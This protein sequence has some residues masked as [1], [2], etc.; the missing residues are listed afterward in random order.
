MAHGPLV[1]CICKFLLPVHVSDKIVQ[2][3]TIN[4][5]VKFMLNE[6]KTFGTFL[7]CEKKDSGVTVTNKP[8]YFIHTGKMN[9]KW[10]LGLIS[11][12]DCN[13]VL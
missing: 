6:N 8:Y 5:E 12:N 2:I 13:C 3:M 9:I 7:Y 1:H 11:D 10:I 4:T